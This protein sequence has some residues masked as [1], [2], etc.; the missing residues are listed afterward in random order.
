MDPQKKNIK[1]LN[2]RIQ[3]QIDNAARGLT[4][5]LLDL[6]SLSLLAFMDASFANNKDL[7]SQI[8]FV[9]VLTDYNQDVNILYWSSIKCKQV[10]CSVLASELYTLAYG[11]D[12]VAVIRL[13]I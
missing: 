7:L 2:K 8:G 9:I 1:Q 3:W 4:F 13:I 6:N 12:I 11:F 5:V 10:I